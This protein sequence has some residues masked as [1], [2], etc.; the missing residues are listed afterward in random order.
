M[1]SYNMWL[2]FLLS[3]C[4]ILYKHT[5]L[6]RNVSV[7]SNVHVNFTSFAGQMHSFILDIYVGGELLSYEVGCVWF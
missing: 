2:I 5:L 3:L 1:E 6:L 7:A 4:S